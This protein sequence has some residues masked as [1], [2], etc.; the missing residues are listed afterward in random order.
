MLAGLSVTVNVRVAVSPLSPSVTVGESI[1]KV[2]TS[3]SVI[4]PVPTAV[5]IGVSDGFG[6]LSRIF[7]VSSD[8]ASSSP[9]TVTLIVF[10]LS[11]AANVSVLLAKAA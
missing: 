10:D 5:E 7:I 11:P 1:D 4:V 9:V 3:S 6:L 2:G 8:S